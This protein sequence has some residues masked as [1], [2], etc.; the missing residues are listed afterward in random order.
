MS[1]YA[2]AGKMI[3]F[4][5]DDDDEGTLVGTA[6]TPFEATRVVRKLKTGHPALMA[7]G[8]K[9]C[10]LKGYKQNITVI[11]TFNTQDQARKAAAFL[12]AFFWDED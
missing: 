7:D 1:D 8:K 6:L 10:G 4:M 2:A 11:Q 9:L 3:W 5:K 12:N